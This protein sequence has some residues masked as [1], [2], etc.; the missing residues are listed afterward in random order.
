[1]VRRLGDFF[2]FPPAYS[3]GPQDA[4]PG[5]PQPAG[6]GYF[7]PAYIRTDRRLSG[8]SPTGRLGIFHAS[9]Q[10]RR[11]GSSNWKIW[12]IAEVAP[13]CLAV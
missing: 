13:L 8:N 12:G 5:I 4:T 6:W 7:T 10:P 11:H 9:L 2:P 3:E 1:M